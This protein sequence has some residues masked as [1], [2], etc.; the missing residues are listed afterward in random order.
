MSWLNWRLHRTEAAI[1][2]LL[3]AGLLAIM[4]Y[5]MGSVESARDS[6]TEAGC[7]GSS[8]DPLCTEQ[9]SNY[10]DRLTSWD[11]LTAPLHG[12]PVAIAILL[13]IPTLHELE[14][15]THRLAWTQSLSRGR[16]ALSRIGFAAGVAAVVA[17]VWAVIAAEWRDAVI[18][19]DMPSFSQNAFGLAP[20]V[21]IGY[22]L[23]AVALGFCLA[24][25]IRRLVPV[26]ALL[27]VGFIGIRVF[28]ALYLRERYRDPE[29]VT[30]ASAF[31]E[32]LGP[33]SDLVWDV[34]SS[35]LS[36]TG[37]R[38]SWDE[39][40]QL[41]STDEA[42]PAGELPYQS[43]IA[44]NGLHFWRSFHPLDRYEQFQAI[45]S[46]L[47]LGGA[48]VLFALAYWWLTRRTA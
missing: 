32:E 29:E 13:L 24:V 10:F 2:V 33:T 4:F 30:V 17:I 6:A 27:V 22:S 38:M 14:R 31:G 3:F 46:A 9:L 21:L 41:C 45:E 23:F 34:D 19:I 36:R 47:F 11:R 39:F 28:T 7:F 18:Q 16:W 40:Y 5:G 43:C 15:G 44:D 48:A 20:A 8:E 35:W 26:L 1:G 12:I 25:V 37:E 42:T